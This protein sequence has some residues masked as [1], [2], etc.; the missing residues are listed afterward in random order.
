MSELLN[1]TDEPD[2]WDSTEPYDDIE[3][4]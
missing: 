1:R 3:I 2:E 4:W